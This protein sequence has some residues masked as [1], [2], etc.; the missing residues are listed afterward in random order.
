MKLV[1]LTDIHGKIDGIEQIAETL[2]AADLILLTGDITNFGWRSRHAARVVEAIKNFNARI[3]AVPGNCDTEV[4]ARY[5]DTTGINLHGTVQSSGGIDFLGVGGSIPCPGRTPNEYS[6]DELEQNLH[7]AAREL[8][9]K[10][11]FIMVSHQPPFGTIVDQIGN[12]KNVGSHAVRRFIEK[13]QPAV[14]F[15]GH[16]HEGVGRDKIGETQVINPG[17]FSG[18]GYTYAEIDEKVKILEIR[19]WKK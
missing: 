3:L 4:V 1:A 7:L 13:Y 17:P 10:K 16:I 8:R 11:D 15:T 6:E 5:L 9:D 18:G 19:S 14:C 2:K 12:G